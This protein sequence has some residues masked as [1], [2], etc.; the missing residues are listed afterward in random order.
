MGLAALAAG[1]GFAS[2]GIGTLTPW[3]AALVAAIVYLV[4]L[5]ASGSIGQTERRLALRLLGRVPS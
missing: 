1:R 5:L 4:C 2:L 3:L